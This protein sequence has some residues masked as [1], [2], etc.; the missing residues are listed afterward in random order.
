MGEL[1]T[2]IAILVQ[3]NY[4]GGF[5]QRQMGSPLLAK[6]GGKGKC[7]SKCKRNGKGQ[8]RSCAFGE[9]MTVVGEG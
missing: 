9:G 1:V 3:K 6:E 2:G 7:N 5:L 8:S 4:G